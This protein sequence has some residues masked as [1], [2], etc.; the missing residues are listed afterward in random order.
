MIHAPP[1]SSGSLVRLLKSIEAADYFG[2]RRPHLTIELPAE[3]DSPTSGFLENLVWPPIDQSGG[4]HASQVTLRHR[5][6]RYRFTTEEA[7]THFIESF[8]P[9]RPK[10]SHVLLLSPQVELSPLY[11]HYVLYNILHYKYA[12]YARLTDATKAL[13]GFSLEQ[14]SVYLNNS[15]GLEPPML[16]ALSETEGESK[17][18]EHTPFLW[19][20][21]NSNAALYFGDKWVELHSFLSARIASRNLHHAS[22]HKPPSRQKIVS[23][24]YP[25]WMEYVQELMRTRGYSLLYPHFPVKSDALVTIHNELYQLPEEFSPTHPDFS[26]NPVPAVDPYDPFIVDSSAHTPSFATHQESP[27]L[28]TKLLALL[29]EFGPSIL[30][31]LASLPILSHDGNLISSSISESIAKT[32]ADDFRRE[33][34]RCGGNEPIIHYHMSAN[35]LFCHSDLH[36]GLPT[37]Y[38][39]EKQRNKKNEQVPPREIIGSPLQYPPKPA[40]STVK[41]LAN[42]GKEIDHEFAA[43]LGRQNPKF[44][45]DQDK[46]MTFED[47]E[48]E[49]EASDLEPESRVTAKMSDLKANVQ[50]VME[51]DNSKT[52]DIKEIALKEDKET[53]K[54]I[55]QSSR[56]SSTPPDS[57]GSLQFSTETSTPRPITPASLSL[58]APAESALGYI[59][60]D[61]VQPVIR[62]PGW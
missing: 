12:T 58:N 51:D 52:I 32:F 53:G 22:E 29:P 55:S 62:H 23:E 2:G 59:E 47:D 38:S 56:S 3:V 21:P 4:S 33:I 1:K 14:P 5:L 37:D 16:E 17:I 34:G 40:E 18:R 44:G 36:D 39:A 45:L 9:A 57:Q 30:L 24:Y 7:S 11:Y 13:M 26:S 49:T 48:F 61:F 35:D 54:P 10:D 6:P 20:A 19:Q 8:Y 46:A 41:T 60:A 31:D 28:T 27:L 25:S 50:T 15:A 42:E 43:H